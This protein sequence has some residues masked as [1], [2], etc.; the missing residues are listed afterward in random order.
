MY[1]WIRTPGNT[2]FWTWP[3]N[4][5]SSSY[6]A[7]LLSK[8]S[9]ISSHKW[10]GEVTLQ[11]L[12]PSCIIT[13]SHQTVSQVFHYWQPV[14]ERLSPWLHFLVSEL[15]HLKKPSKLKFVVVRYC[16]NMAH[17]A[18]QLLHFLGLDLFFHANRRGNLRCR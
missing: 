11:I 1:G 14:L 4:L 13:T 9:L 15:S 8:P 3:I 2:V 17:E 12:S 5:A 7:A 6:S 18:G 16:L 10:K